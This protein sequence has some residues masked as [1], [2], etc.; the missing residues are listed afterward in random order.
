MKVNGYSLDQ[1]HILKIVSEDGSV[2]L[3]ELRWV[4]NNEKMGKVFLYF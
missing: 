2:D 1:A 3:Y 4:S